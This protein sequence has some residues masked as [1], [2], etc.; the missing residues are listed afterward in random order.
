MKKEQVHTLQR[1]AQR[2]PIT[3]E[4]DGINNERFA[5]KVSN[6][7]SS[8]TTT[9]SGPLDFLNTYTYQMTTEGYLMGSGAAT[10]LSAGA[11]FWSK[12]GRTLYNATVGQ[13]AY[14]PSFTNGTSRPKPVL[15]TTSQARIENSMLNWALGFFGSTLSTIP[16]L[17]LSDITDVYEKVVITEGGTE[18]D[19]L[20]S[21]DSCINEYATDVVGYM[22]DNLVW[23]YL[24]KYLG[25]A[26][27]RMQQNAP[28]GFTFTVNVSIN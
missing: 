10:E 22:G 1:H 20:A 27:A 23:G 12:Y 4:D 15:R 2:L 18:N 17:T 8:A 26:T 11:S 13:L 28:E 3:Y 21:Y 9:F 25:P 7:T 24:E 6:S 19:T 16:D 14:S 5:Q